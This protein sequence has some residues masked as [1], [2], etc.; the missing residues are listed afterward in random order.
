MSSP[1]NGPKPVAIEP[2]T[3]GGSPAAIYLADLLVQKN[4]PVL[5]RKVARTLAE[6][7]SLIADIARAHL[8]FDALPTKTLARLLT[9]ISTHYQTQI[10]E[11]IRKTDA[12]VANLVINI[13]EGGLKT[14]K[15]RVQ[16][17]RRKERVMARSRPPGA[18]AQWLPAVPLLD[19]VSD[20]DLRL[21]SKRNLAKHGKLDTLY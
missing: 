9:L 18:A 16:E 21:R 15:R 8:D 20:E 19:E 11:P 3:F 10:A 13:L 14:W 5:A 17:A 4:D 12:H 2:R 1:R 6:G 7:R